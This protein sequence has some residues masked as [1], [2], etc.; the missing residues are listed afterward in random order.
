MYLTPRVG[1][2]AQL[3]FVVLASGIVQLASANVVTE[4]W[5]EGMQRK[6]PSSVRAG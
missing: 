4:A 2:V 3:F 1:F 5:T 6:T